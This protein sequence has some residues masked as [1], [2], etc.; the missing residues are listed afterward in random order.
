MFDVLFGPLGVTLDQ[1][2]INTVRTDFDKI[3]MYSIF[4]YAP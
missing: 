1:N 4:K 3:V 2:L